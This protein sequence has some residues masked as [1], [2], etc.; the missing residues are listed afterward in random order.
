LNR[1]ALRNPY[2]I[3]GSDKA[4]NMFSWKKIKE[5]AKLMAEHMAAIAA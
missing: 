1:V 3:D 2:S 5:S 4:N